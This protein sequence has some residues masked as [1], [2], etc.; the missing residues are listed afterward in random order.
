MDCPC[1]DEFY[2]VPFVSKSLQYLL[3]EC[4]FKFEAAHVKS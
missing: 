4:N 1:V 2:G 3:D